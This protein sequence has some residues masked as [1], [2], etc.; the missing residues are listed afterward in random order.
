MVEMGDEGRDV[1]RGKG[2]R[3][4]K[5]ARKGSYFGPVQFTI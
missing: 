2:E 4:T 5:K 1:G 3:M